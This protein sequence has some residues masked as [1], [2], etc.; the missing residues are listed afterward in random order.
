MSESRG[1][2]IAWVNDLLGLSY[3]KIEQLGSGAAY[4]QIMDSIYGDL[5][6]S[7]IKFSSKH[8]YEYLG[9]YKVLQ[10]CFQQHKVD[11]SIPTDRLMKCK[12]QDNLEFTQW[13]KKYWDAYFPG[14]PYDAAARRGASGD[15]PVSNR[16]AAAPPRRAMNSSSSA[17]NRSV[18]GR[19]SVMSAGN[20]SLRKQASPDHAVVL[21]LQKELQEERNTVAALEKER[22]FYFG[23]LRDIEVLIQQDLERSSEMADSPLLKEIQ[24]VLYSTEEGFEIP[25]EDQAAA[26]GEYP[27]ETF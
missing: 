11:K 25:E 24:A 1:E 2:L 18:T 8:E 10:T 16:S 7:R 17:A 9:N 5:P 3:T 6:M 23:K 21:N 26:E 14:G 4:V 13:L 19:G 12:M 22:D 15:V 20:T 27:D